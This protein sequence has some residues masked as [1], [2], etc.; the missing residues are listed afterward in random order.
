MPDEHRSAFG[1]GWEYARRGR[2]LM[3]NPFHFD[4]MKRRWFREGWWSYRGE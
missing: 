2:S 3:N 4:T 1:L